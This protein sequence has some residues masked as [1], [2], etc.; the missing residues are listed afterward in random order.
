MTVTVRPS[1]AL[2]LTDQ[3]GNVRDCQ[4]QSR[5]A[6]PT[7]LTPLRLAFTTAWWGVAHAG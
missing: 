7:V 1:A 5:P 4:V 3:S 6:T 2:S